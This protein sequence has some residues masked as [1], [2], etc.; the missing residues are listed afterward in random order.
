MH[1]PF[2]IEGGNLHNQTKMGAKDLTVE[3]SPSPPLLNNSY[4]SASAFLWLG[5]MPF[6][7]PFEHF[8]DPT[9]GRRSGQSPQ[10]LPCSQGPSMKEVE[11]VIFDEYMHETFNYE[12]ISGTFTIVQRY[13]LIVIVIIQIFNSPS[14]TLPLSFVLTQSQTSVIWITSV[15]WSV[16][17][18]S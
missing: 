15:S 9:S 13:R 17:G 7:K 2:V 1:T 18:P 4:R 5:Q 14:N 16:P 8:S 3:A 11:M 10:H 12:Y 6:D